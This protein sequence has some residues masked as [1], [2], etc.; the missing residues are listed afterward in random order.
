MNLCESC[1]KVGVCTWKGIPQVSLPHRLITGFGACNQC[2]CH[3]P[4]TLADLAAKDAEIAK[5]KDEVHSERAHWQDRIVRERND[6]MDR[7]ANGILT[8]IAPLA[9]KPCIEETHGAG[10]V[11]V[12]RVWHDENEV[13]KAAESLGFVD[14]KRGP[15]PDYT[16]EGS[17]WVPPNVKPHTFA[18]M[19]N[20]VRDLAFD[21]GASEQFR[22][23]V[24]DLLGKYI[25]VEHGSKGEP[26]QTEAPAVV[27]PEVPMGT[28]LQR[29]GLRLTQILDGHEFAVLE[30]EFLNPAIEEMQKLSV[31]SDRVLGDGEVKMEICERDCREDDEDA[32]EVLRVCGY[33]QQA[34]M[35]EVAIKAHDLR[36]NQEGAAT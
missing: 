17:A 9:E 27:V 15:T 32:L 7:A 33:G 20:E 5:L 24:A 3:D 6:T 26:E 21:F 35:L 29:L 13:R 1:K 23:R 18:Q 16:G 19:V 34:E 25:H 22:D 36:A 14:L 30:H 28:A 4:I 8:A 12:G 10:F 11:L 31:L 2:D